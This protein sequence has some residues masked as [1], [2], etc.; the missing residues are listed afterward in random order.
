MKKTSFVML[1]N[2]PITYDI[3]DKANSFDY[4]FRINQRTNFLTTGTN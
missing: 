1:G 3:S 2:G 4:V